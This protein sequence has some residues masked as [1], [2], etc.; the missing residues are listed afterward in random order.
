MPWFSF[1][2]SQILA[3]GLYPFE[4]GCGMSSD[5]DHESLA[6]C[7]ERVAD[8]GGEDPHLIDTREFGENLLNARGI[9]GKAS[10]R[11]SSTMGAG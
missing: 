4:T 3:L 1:F 9:L 6:C 2:P 5:P 7:P 11:G 8:H 10:T